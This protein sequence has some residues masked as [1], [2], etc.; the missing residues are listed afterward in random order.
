MQIPLWHVKFADRVCIVSASDR[1]NAK[2]NA[3]TWM[4]GDIEQYIVSPLTTP[5]S[6]VHLAITVNA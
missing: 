4:G 5:E 1:E 3:Y 6:Q 2:R